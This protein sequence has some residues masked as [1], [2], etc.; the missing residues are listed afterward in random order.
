MNPPPAT[1]VPQAGPEAGFTLIEALIVTAV[2]SVLAVGLVLGLGRH[3]P[4]SSDQA[5]F[6][7]A[8]GT[9]QALAVQGRETRGIFVTDRGMGQ[10]V[11]TAEGW[12]ELG[13]GTRWRGRV[14]LSAVRSPG[15]SDAPE[16][17]LLPTGEASV[18][19]VSFADAGGTA[20]ADGRCESDGWSGLTC[21]GG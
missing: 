14:S 21:V 10:A 18:F 17:I 11:L 12:L 3:G 16:V 2:L 20:G 13:R 8:F 5:R 7:R 15:L 9:A 1:S 4:G 19:S 6:A